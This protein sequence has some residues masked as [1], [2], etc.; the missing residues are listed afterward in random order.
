MKTFVEGS[1]DHIVYRDCIAN[2]RSF[3]YCSLAC[4]IKKVMEEWCVS[5]VRADWLIAVC[6]SNLGDMF[7]AATATR[8]AAATTVTAA[9]RPDAAGT[10]A[11]DDHCNS[12]FITLYLVVFRF[13]S[14][15]LCVQCKGCTDI[16]SLACCAADYIL[17]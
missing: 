3:I 17:L 13:M 15:I 2:R 5:S 7:I 8:T 6:H 11:T 14:V 1:V 4:R 9:V 12:I 16:S 10:T